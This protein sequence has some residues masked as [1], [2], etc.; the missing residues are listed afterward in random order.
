[1]TEQLPKQKK[2]TANGQ[3]KEKKMEKERA[4]DNTSAGIESGK[5]NREIIQDELK[6]TVGGKGEGSG[7]CPYTPDRTCKTSQ[8][9]WEDSEV[10]RECGWRAW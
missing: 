5:E 2:Q 7:Y 9:G 8:G 10:C 6:S 3:R 1:M 4:S